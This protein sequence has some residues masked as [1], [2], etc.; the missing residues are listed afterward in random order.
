[1]WDA[2]E[3]FPVIEC[4]HKFPRFPPEVEQYCRKNLWKY[5][6]GWP[7]IHHSRIS[8]QNYWNL[9]ASD[10]GSNHFHFIHT[11]PAFPP[12]LIYTF[13]IFLIGLAVGHGSWG[14]APWSHSWASFLHMLSSCLA[15]PSL[16]SISE[17]CW[18][19]SKNLPLC[20][21]PFSLLSEGLDCY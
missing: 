18:W 4:W 16:V 7:H 3:S 20:S 13:G 9:Q 8:I 11:L 12:M 6:A 17:T 15:V 5:I 19:E 21:R 1:M 10:S 14:P 2:A